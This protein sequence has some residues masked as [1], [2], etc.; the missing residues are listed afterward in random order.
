MGHLVYGKV[1]H[2]RVEDCDTS[3]CSFD[4]GYLQIEKVFYDRGAERYTARCRLY[5][6]MLEYPPR[7]DHFLRC[8]ECL[9]IFDRLDTQH[10]QSEYINF[11]EIAS[12]I[13]DRAL[14]DNV[15]LRD[16]FSSLCHILWCLLKK[17]SDFKHLVTEVLAVEL[18]EAGRRAFEAGATVSQ[19]QRKDKIFPFIDWDNL[20][21]QAKEGKR[22]QAKFI[23]DNLFWGLDYNKNKSD[24]DLINGCCCADLIL[25][26][27]I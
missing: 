22:I 27:E 3:L 6:K 7:D 13:I 11:M 15:S 2:I 17:D 25:E 24:E 18:H 5:D 26:E 20:T 23:L 14:K 10:R 8:S 1:C 12:Q 9:N 21:E 19:A 4:C 16:V